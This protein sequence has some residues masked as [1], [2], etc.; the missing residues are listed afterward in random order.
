MR[1]FIGWSCAVGLALLSACDSNGRVSGPQAP[2]VFGSPGAALTDTV[3]VGTWTF[4]IS[5]V[6][7]FG[8]PRS[9]ETTW[10]F[11]SDGSAIRSV[12]TRNFLDGIADRRDSFARW[13]VQG[14]QLVIDFTSPFT[15]RVPL[16]FQ[17]NGDRLI[18]GGQTFLRA[19]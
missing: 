11:N 17:R 7:D 6:D 3:V 19:F 16:T 18:L 9:T 8:V 2:L 14:D 1:R 13:V 15:G 10:T 5:F 12:I 4:K